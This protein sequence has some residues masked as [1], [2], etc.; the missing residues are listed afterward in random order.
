VSP[1]SAAVDIPATS[2]PVER[3]T[4]PNGLRVVLAPDRSAPVIGVAVVYDVGIR[5]EPEG[6]TGFAHLFEHLM[7]QGSAN[8]EKLAHFRYVQGS[9]GTF[10]GSTHLD[11]TDYFETL[12][13]NA[14]ERTLF[15]EADR[16]RG[17]RLNEENLRNQ[18]DVVKE[19]IR[20]NVLNRPYG[21]FPWLRLPPVMFDT[22]PNA[23]DGYGSFVDLESATV[24]DAQSFFERYYA[25]GNAVLTV[26]GDFD[27]AE[28][29]RL[30]ESHF[31][32]VPTRPAP[33][34]PDFDEPDLTSE[35]RS[36][37]VD[38]LAPLP[39]VASAWRVPNPVTDF[40][41]YLPYVV[42]AEV[43]T[44]GD[45]SRL[46][47]RLVQRDR[48]A[49]SVGGYLG[50]M[51]EPFET[52]DPTA[53]I[54]QYHLPPAGD[55]DKV[56]RTTDEE[57]E[58]IATDGLQ[59]GELERTVARMATHLLRDSDAV[60]SRV[61]RMAVLEQQRGDAGLINQLPSLLGQVTREQVTAAAA[62]L[63]PARRATVEVEVPSGGTSK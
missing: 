28:A 32:D 31:G 45:A 22:F 60:L 33:Q 21:G 39:A 62:L 20:L 40:S 30:V 43:L 34:R 44:D 13:A 2:Y 55:V 25:A 23:H 38:R 18:V 29:T 51:G 50:M 61:L 24:A 6:R 41:G 17:P 36:S 3:F 47:Q 48:A 57:L 59:D 52:R 19:E 11:Y 1:R 53:I 37:Y 4:L 12:P 7:F 14:L 49:T 46:V 63:R 15:L 16:M 26:G 8:L 35:R 27:V 5:S 58:R 56:L 54:L 42:L 10:N 9:G